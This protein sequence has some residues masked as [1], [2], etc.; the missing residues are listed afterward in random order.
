MD[1]AKKFTCQTLVERQSAYWYAKSVTLHPV[2]IYYREESGVLG[3]KTLC[4]YQISTATPQQ[5]F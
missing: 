5:Q 1:F 2:L 3:S 4:M